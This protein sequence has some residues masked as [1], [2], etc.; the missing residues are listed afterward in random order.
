MT[1]SFSGNDLGTDSNGNAVQF[2]GTMVPEDATGT[3]IP[4]PKTVSSTAIALVVPAG[5]IKL[6][7]YPIGADLRVG[8]N[9]DLD[10]SA[11]LKGYVFVAEDTWKEFDVANGDTIYVLRNASVDVTLH[12]YFTVLKS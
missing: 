12:F 5:A 6:A 3:P 9:S 11:T 10:G 8:D 1:V 4:S 2:G 7:V